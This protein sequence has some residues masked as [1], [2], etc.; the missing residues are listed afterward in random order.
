MSIFS[1]LAS[2][3]PANIFKALKPPDPDDPDGSWLYGASDGMS[4]LSAFGGE[5]GGY[6]GGYQTVGLPGGATPV[7]FM[8]LLPGI[9][10]LILTR[11]VT[12]LWVLVQLHWPMLVLF[13]FLKPMID[14]PR[15]RKRRGRGR[16][17][18]TIRV[19]RGRGF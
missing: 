17:S 11:L 18:Q 3:N 6:G 7:G 14:P 12:W 10:G 1:A 16:R 8:P 4:A 15:R 13:W 2:G 5:G 19:V 9:A